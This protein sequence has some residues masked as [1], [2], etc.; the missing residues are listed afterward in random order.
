[1][2]EDTEAFRHDSFVKFFRSKKK[3]VKFHVIF[4]KKNRKTWKIKKLTEK[5]MEV[6]GEKLS[7]KNDPTLTVSKYCLVRKKI[8][9]DCRTSVSAV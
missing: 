6:T 7:E 3:Q 1:M 9:Y 4:G 5:N 2:Y 8:Y